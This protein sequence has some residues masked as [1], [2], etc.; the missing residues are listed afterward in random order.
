MRLGSKQKYILSAL[1]HHGYWGPLCGWVWD[2]KANTQKV[3]ESLV[4]KSLVR[5]VKLYYY[6]TALGFGY[7]YKRIKK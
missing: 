7:T 2:S 6:P 5:R 4:K 3:L 1:I